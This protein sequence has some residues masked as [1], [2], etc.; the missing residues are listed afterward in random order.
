MTLRLVDLE[1]GDPRLSS[2]ILPVLLDLRPHLT[3]ESFAAIYAEG[4]PAGLR[5]TAAYD[6]DRC[7]GVAGW[8]FV[9]TTFATRKLYVD[10]LVTEPSGRSKGVG[11]A[12]IAELERRAREAGCSVLDLD[13]G[14]HRFDAHRFY[15]REGLTISAHHF[16]KRLPE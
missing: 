14:V 11:K 16:T 3:P 13:S 1:P 12:L 9:A 8:R 5:Y 15:H 7:V 4:H 6:D 2:D 10:D